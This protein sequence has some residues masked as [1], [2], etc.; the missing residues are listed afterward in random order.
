M[1]SVI[2]KWIPRLWSQELCRFDHIWRDGLE[3]LID[4]A[5]KR[6]S[7]VRHRPFKRKNSNWAERE[8]RGD[9][10]LMASEMPHLLQIIGNR[11]RAVI[12]TSVFLCN[13]IHMT[14]RCTAISTERPSSYRIV[15]CPGAE[16]SR[17]SVQH[18]ETRRSDPDPRRKKK[19]KHVS[20]FPSLSLAPSYPNKGS[21]L[22]QKCASRSA[23]P[24]S[25][26]SLIRKKAQGPLR[27]RSKNNK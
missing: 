1:V 8:Q 6:W 21:S 5:R 19:K 3:T 17:Y 15:A 23:H 12:V 7:P 16:S 4:I 22:C 25:A 11:A 18:R 27:K 2:K 20:S 24:V 14:P 26:C 13:S 9:R 10:I